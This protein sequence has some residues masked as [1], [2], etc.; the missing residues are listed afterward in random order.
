M[1]K[2]LSTLMAL[3][4]ILTMLMAACGATPEPAPEPTQAEAQPE[5]TQ[6]EAQPEPTEEAAPEP[7][8]E[9]QPEATTAPEPE[10][11]V[12]AATKP[13]KLYAVQHAQCSFD[14]FWCTVEDGIKTAAEAMGVEVTILAPDKFDLEKTAQ[15][16]EQAV[17]AQPDG[18]ALT[19]TDADLFR[20]PIQKALD[21]GIP[22]VAYN[23]GKGPVA[24][25]IAY[26]TY[27]GQDEY[28]GG[29]Q[30]GQ[31]LAA[32]GGTGGVCINQQV[33]H[34]GL[35]ARCQGFVDALTEQDIPAE[36]LA[37]SDDPAASQTV[38]SDY[39]TA[40]PD[41]DI[42]LTLGP[43]GANP[44][45]AFM[46]A[47]GLAAGDIK[48][49]TFDLSP[50]IN[51]KIKDGTTMFG[52]DQQPFLQGW[53]AVE[54]LT[55][56]GRYGIMPALPVSATGPGFVTAENVDFEV[57]A[58]RAINVYM[59]QHAL[60]SWDAFWCVV[61]NGIEQAA[62][63]LNIE[64]TLLGP[65]KWDLEK[66]AQ[67]IEQ[68]VAAQPDG[69]GVT[70]SD[71][72]LFRAPIQKAIDASVPVV[73]YNAGQ[74]PLED[75]IAYMTYLGQ[76]E[77]QGGYLGG[78]RLAA[79]GGTAGVCINQVV[80]H[81]GLDRRC[82]GFVD[83]LTEKGIAAEVLAISDDPAA[84][85]TVISDYYT[86][87]PDTDIFLTLGPNGATPFYAFM[88]AQGLAAGD[89]KHGTFDLGPQIIAKIKDGTTMFGID[90]QPFLQG[91]GA[92]RTLALRLR[93]GISPA[94]PVTATGPGFVDLTNVDLVESLAGTYR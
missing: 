13:L 46:E 93:Y 57:D 5:A 39:Y 45:Y 34:T 84:S 49:G 83:A 17:A 40:N 51:E 73:A 21:A 74:G 86:A 32:D 43:N 27:L 85:Q 88:D 68:A 52:I 26:L 7:T 38:I 31:R 87:N 70:V 56:V 36:V 29:Y 91:Y 64:Y 14:A 75:N 76:D 16:I 77:Y 92:M 12:D 18:L 24:D 61:T 82:K 20:A 37:I 41:T 62:K 23:A 72:D 25:G 1:S 19:V 4:V 59:V 80:G 10:P 44:F 22:V 63:E 55:M 9:P 47:A 35:D 69:M 66:M 67:L 48:H 28:A 30:G 54:M 89:I 78:M 3:L 8:E 79:D 42:F 2:K 6:V 33:G 50:E 90:Q 65:D 71:A 58:E 60:C 53:G 15:L 81:T 94:L 11:A